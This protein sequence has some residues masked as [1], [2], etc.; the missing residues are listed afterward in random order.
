NP[1]RVPDHQLALLVQE[2]K[3]VIDFAKGV[4]QMQRTPDAEAFWAWV[5]PELTREHFDLVGKLLARGAAHVTRLSALYA[6]F[7][8]RAEITIPD[9][10]SALAVW[11]YSKGSVEI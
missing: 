3:D 7:A 6:L 11:Q 9:I 1:P 4:K 5:Y 8:R 10:V 2:V